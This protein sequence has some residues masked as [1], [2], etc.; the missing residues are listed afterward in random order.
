[1]MTEKF[2]GEF[3]KNSIEA[4]KNNAAKGRFN[5]LATELIKKNFDI[6]NKPEKEKAFLF[7]EEENSNGFPWE[8]FGFSSTKDIEKK[9][10]MNEAENYSIRMER[11]PSKLPTD[12]SRRLLNENEIFNQNEWELSSLE[13]K[14][15]TLN[16]A[17]KI[18]AEEA[19]FPDEMIAETNVYAC[20]LD[21]PSKKAFA[22]LFVDVDKNGNLYKKDVAGIYINAE[23]L[24]N[25]SYSLV[26]AITS[27][28]HES[29]HIMQQ[30]SLCESGNT[31]AYSE[32]QKEWKA[33]I[34]ERLE[35]AKKSNNSTFKSFVDYVTSPLETYAHMQTDY[36]VKIL[37]AVI[38][39]GV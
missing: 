14:I 31:F 1:M 27:V 13:E 22:N 8:N 10:L 3:A 12:V 25:P 19:C 9:I 2:I 28:Y 33:D 29:I 7:L 15:E 4:L 37:D 34:L 20:N 21:S 38:Y 39:E 32:M 24:S 35:T 17:F 36:F 23:N 18:I 16:K 26:D 6:E 11:H 5:R 30:L